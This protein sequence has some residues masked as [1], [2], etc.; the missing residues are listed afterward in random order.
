S[1]A[2]SDD[3]PLA[4]E[5]RAVDAFK[6]AALM[7]FGVA[8]QTYGTKLADEQEVLTFTADMLID[9]FSAE[10]ALLRAASATGPRAS[11][12]I[13]AARA[14]INDAAGRIEITARHAL[15]AMVAGDTLRTMLAGLRRVLKVSPIDAVALR[16]RLADEAVA[17]GG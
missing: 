6:K 17:R 4:E 5:R 16:R 9:V 3:T 2:S 13:D 7:V 12:H 14:F 8:M 11:L 1:M 15:A 10:S